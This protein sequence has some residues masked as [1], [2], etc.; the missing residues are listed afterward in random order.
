MS[1]QLDRRAIYPL[2]MNKYMQS[3]ISILHKSFNY[4][5]SRSRSQGLRL[6]SIGLERV[7]FLRPQAEISPP[8]WSSRIST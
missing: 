7:S 3:Q 4:R 6:N 2:N 1:E 5:F 8:Y